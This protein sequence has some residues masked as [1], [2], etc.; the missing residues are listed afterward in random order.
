MNVSKPT[1][2]LTCHIRDVRQNFFDNRNCKS[3]ITK[4]TYVAL[5]LTLLFYF[6]VGS[7]TIVY[8]NLNAGNYILRIEAKTESGERAVIRRAIRIGITII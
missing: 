7:P 8:P 4:L 5:S 2:S 3:Q 1:S 6:F